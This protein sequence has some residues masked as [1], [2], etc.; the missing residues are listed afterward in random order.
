MNT[1]KARHLTALLRLHANPSTTSGPALFRRLR[2]IES[3]AN[4]ASTAQ[5]NGESYRGQPYRDCDEQWEAFEASIERR[6]KC[7]FGGAIPAGFFFNQDPRGYSLK[8]ESATLP[9]GLTTDWGSYG[10]LAP[11][12]RP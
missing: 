12:F 3:D 5:C 8:I 10:V 7:A 6:V 1:Y 4:A 9:D 11:T 2:R